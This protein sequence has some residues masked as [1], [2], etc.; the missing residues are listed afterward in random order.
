MWSPEI[1]W[2][3]VDFSPSLCSQHNHTVSCVCTSNHSRGR[4]MTPFI[5]ASRSLARRADCMCWSV[6]RS[7]VLFRPTLTSPAPPSSSST[8]IWKPCSQAE[9]EHW[10]HLLLSLWVVGNFVISWFQSCYTERFMYKSFL[11]QWGCRT[12]LVWVPSCNRIISRSF[13]MCCQT[14]AGW[15]FASS[16]C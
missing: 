5:T 7:I 9:P 10:P 16:S 15:C 6:W 3:R 1:Q 11:Q 4:R 14:A 13:C 8:V 2:E 12:T